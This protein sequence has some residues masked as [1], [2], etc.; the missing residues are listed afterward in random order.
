MCFNDDFMIDCNCNIE[1]T[2]E[3]ETGDGYEHV[4][5]QITSVVTSFDQRSS[6]EATSK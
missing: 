2:A 1:W 4:V 3:D 6:G 5:E